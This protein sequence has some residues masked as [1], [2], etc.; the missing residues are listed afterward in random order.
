M[1]AFATAKKN[2][3]VIVVE[4][5]ANVYGYYNKIENQKFIHIN[6]SLLECSRTYLTA[7]LLYYALHQEDEIHLLSKDF[8]EEKDAIKYAFEMLQVKEDIP[9][10]DMK[11]L[12]ERLNRFWGTDIVAH[13]HTT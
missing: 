8:A 7:H 6:D 5:L 12:F 3:V 10:E 2:N 1:T 13:L 9:E 11:K 4:P